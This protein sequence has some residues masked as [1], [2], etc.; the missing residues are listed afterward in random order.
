M[1]V[2]SP[3]SEERFNQDCLQ[4]FPLQDPPKHKLKRQMSTD[5]NE[6]N[7]NRTQSYPSKRPQNTDVASHRDDRVDASLANFKFLVYGF[8]GTLAIKPGIP[9]TSLSIV[10]VSRAS[11]LK[12]QMS[13]LIGMIAWMLP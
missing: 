10:F 9:C 4:P 2:H 11:R 13:L 12:I 8:S 3:I 5:S 7:D 6:S 1:T